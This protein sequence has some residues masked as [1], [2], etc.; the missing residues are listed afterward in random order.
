MAA[1]P[2]TLANRIDREY[3]IP[4]LKWSMG[5]WYPVAGRYLY[6][7]VTVVNAASR[8]TTGTGPDGQA[9]RGRYGDFAPG[10]GERWRVFRI[11]GGQYVFEDLA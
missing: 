1:D 11:A 8:T 4:S 10:V 3:T 5:D 2:A 7:T 6:A 9:I